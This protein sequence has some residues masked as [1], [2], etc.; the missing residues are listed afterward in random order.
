MEPIIIGL[1]GKIGVGK[2]TMADYLVENYGF[3]KFSFATALKKIIAI[4]TGWDI[5]FVNGTN[6]DLRPLRETLVHPVYNKTCRQ[7]LQYVGTDL[8]RNQLHSEIWLQIVKKDIEN[9]VELCKSRGQ[10]ARVVI[11][12]VRFPDEAALII[13]TGGMLFRIV[14]DNV[15]D[16]TEKSKTLHISEK[17]FPVEKEII[18]CNDGSIDEYKQ[19]IFQ[20][21]RELL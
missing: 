12:D 4:I 7:M 16:V 13:S 5:E 19:K 11:S 9:Y 20:A 2:D 17:D 6:S 18:I 3:Q 1:R 10:Q 14:K 21:V 8:L 15:A